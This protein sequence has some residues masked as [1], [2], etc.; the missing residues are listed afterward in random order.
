MPI[1]FAAAKLLVGDNDQL[2]SALDVIEPYLPVL[3]RVGKAGLD[4]FL[5]AVRQQ[6]WQRVDRALY[7]EMTEAERDV[8]GGE[9]LKDARAT[10]MRA[11]ESN[12]QWQSD[13]LRLMFGLL[14]S[15]I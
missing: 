2:S 3:K 11:Y 7:A 13:L 15:A 6:D 8:L 1:D 12:R 9:V 5:S 4:A 14:L 10:V